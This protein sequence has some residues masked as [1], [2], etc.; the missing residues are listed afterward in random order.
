MSSDNSLRLACNA[1]LVNEMTAVSG[2]EGL[3]RDSLVK[4]GKHAL[5]GVLKWVGK[6]VADVTINGIKT[7]NTSIIKTL[8][9]R[10]LFLSHLFRK[11]S[12][13]EVK[14]MSVFSETFLKKVTL[15]GTPDDILRSVKVMAET[16]SV[17]LKY[18]VE[19]EAYYHKEMSALKSIESIKTTED[20]VKVVKALDALPLPKPAFTS[21]SN[22]MSKSK[23]LPGG[24]VF[25][26]NSETNRFS[27][28]DVDMETSEQSESLSNE[29]IKEI[30]SEL[31]K[32]ASKYK[33]I[34]KLNENYASYLK[35]FNVVVTDSFHHLESLKGKISP[36][37]LRDLKDRLD[38]NTLV[39]SFYSGFLPKVMI[40]LDDYVDTLSSYLSKQFN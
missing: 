18:G 40:Y 3:L 5:G 28:E 9:T 37:I 21:A 6:G 14:E 31:N 33:D 11:A 23:Q 22:S 12:K 2:S 26:F 7:A 8:G 16:Y 20:A 35:K 13:E 38:G 34:V 1:L 25:A 10:Q 24:S 36:S 27:I 19:L 39:F 29:T 15:N 17:I 30:L 32:L 4:V